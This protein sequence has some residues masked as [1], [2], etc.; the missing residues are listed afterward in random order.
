M[1]LASPRTLSL[2]QFDGSQHAWDLLYLLP[3]LNKHRGSHSGI[4]SGP[5]CNVARKFLKYLPSRAAEHTALDMATS[6]FSKGM[7]ELLGEYHGQRS[8]SVVLVNPTTA[9][10]SSYTHALGAIRQ[11]LFDKKQSSLPETT[12]AVVLLCCFEVCI[13]II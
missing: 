9:L 1:P 3:A 12:I 2:P 10:T 7:R 4:L 11:A 5:V 13:N 6:C 8:V